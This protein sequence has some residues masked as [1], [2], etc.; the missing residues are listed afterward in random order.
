[1]SEQDL[2]VKIID[3]GFRGVNYRLDKMNGRLN[4]HA[5][6]IRVIEWFTASVIGAWGVVKFLWEKK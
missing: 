3:E 4:D 5:K 2:L 6:R 1:M